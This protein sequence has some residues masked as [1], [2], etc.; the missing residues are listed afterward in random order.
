MNPNIEFVNFIQK[1]DQIKSNVLFSELDYKLAKYDTKRTPDYS[2]AILK[3]SLMTGIICFLIIAANYSYSL[4]FVSTGAQVISSLL[5]IVLT[6]L[7]FYYEVN[8]KRFGDFDFKEFLREPIILSV[9]LINI[10][11]VLSC[12]LKL[13]FDNYP[14]QISGLLVFLGII[15]LPVFILRS[16]KILDPLSYVNSL[17][18]NLIQAIKNKDASKIEYILTKCASLLF[19]SIETND[20]P[21][22]KKNVERLHDIGKFYVTT[23][24]AFRHEYLERPLTKNRMSWHSDW[25]FEDILK[26]FQSAFAISLERQRAYFANHILNALSSISIRCLNYNINSHLNTLVTTV[27]VDCTKISA[28]KDFWERGTKRILERHIEYGLKL[29]EKEFAILTFK[30]F[31]ENFIIDLLESRPHIILEIVNSMIWV[32]GNRGYGHNNLMWIARNVDN[33]KSICKNLKAHEYLRGKIKFQNS[34]LVEQLNRNLIL[35]MLLLLFNDKKEDAKKVKKISRMRKNER[36]RFVKQI[37]SDQNLVYSY[38]RTYDASGNE[39]EYSER[40]FKKMMADYD[41]L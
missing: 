7:F 22:F 29:E 2:L 3:F 28:K 9:F 11:A 14:S 32:V 20:L 34:K 13:A 6:I 35:C 37:A 17:H 40:K 31:D 4:D 25:F 16:Q 5:A 33:I 36:R 27:Y 19:L 26:M 15:L 10:L 21:T 18:N 30:I 8:A 23:N 12:L 1:P 41:S 39:R 24:Y 38:F